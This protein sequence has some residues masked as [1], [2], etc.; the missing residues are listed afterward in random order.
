MIFE[1][2]LGP[3]PQKPSAQREAP[4]RV[5]G[6]SPAGAGSAREGKFA[7]FNMISMKILRFLA[8]QSVPETKIHAPGIHQAYTYKTQISTSYTD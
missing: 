7:I 6:G 3:E 2:I 8:C 4:D 1:L 5:Q